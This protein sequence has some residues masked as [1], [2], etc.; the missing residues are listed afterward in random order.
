MPRFCVFDCETSAAWQPIT[1]G[2]MF[3]EKLMRDGDDW[4]I[5]LI[6]KGESIPEDILDYQGIVLTGSHFNCRDSDSLPWFSELCKI[7]QRSFESGK[8]YIYGGCFGC[9]LIAV[10][11]GGEVDYN[12]NKRFLCKVEDILLNDAS[13]EVFLETGDTQNLLLKVIVSH[14]DC[15]TKLPPDSKLIASSKSCANE[16][17]AVGRDSNH[18]NI[19]G[20]QSHP[21][22]DAQY[23]IF[24]RI[25]RYS[26]LKNKRLSEEEIAAYEPGLKS[27]NREDGADRLIE[28]IKDFLHQ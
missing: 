12:P 7:V 28:M 22:F 24:D 3:I 26:V 25:W 17:F 11:L 5:V 4:R 27:F 15:V 6:A 14:G 18:L 20:C 21:E 19:I 10:A 16:I 1:F 9:Q 23:A 13:R 2:M 8:P